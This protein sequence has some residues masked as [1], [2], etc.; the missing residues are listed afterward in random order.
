M[1]SYLW[2]IVIMIQTHHE[3]LAN[4]TFSKSPLCA[5]GLM[6]IGPNENA[7]GPF[8]LVCLLYSPLVCLPSSP[9]TLFFA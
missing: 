3:N 6:E 9:L 8:Y 2:T 4:A 7:L 1:N 5:L